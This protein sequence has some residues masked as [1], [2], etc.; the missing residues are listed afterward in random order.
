MPVGFV[1]MRGLALH[2]LVLR[3]CACVEVTVRVAV[4]VRVMVTVAFGLRPTSG[5]M[6]VW[7]NINQG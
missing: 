1:A 5:F 4:R 2:A 6:C 3:V 7:V